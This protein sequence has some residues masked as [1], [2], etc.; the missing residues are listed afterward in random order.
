MGLILLIN[1][2]FLSTGQ[3]FIE[4]AILVK[5]TNNIFIN[6]TLEVFLW[7]E[8]NCRKQ[9]HKTTADYIGNI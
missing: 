6:V 2:A 5:S 8:K 4:H 3:Q 9:Q 1:N 7:G